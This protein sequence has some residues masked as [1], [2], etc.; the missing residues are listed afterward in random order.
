[1]SRVYN[2]SIHR[3]G[4]NGQDATSSDRASDASLGAGLAPLR[5]GEN[6]ETSLALGGD[7]SSVS[8]VGVS[9]FVALSASITLVF[10]SGGGC[11]MKTPC[12]LMLTWKLRAIVSIF[13][14]TLLH[15]RN[16]LLR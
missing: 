5:E 10:G 6:L 1:M 14:R 13:L 16:W 3:R 8:L 2:M 4:A 11:R 15:C 12:M 7:M 9:S